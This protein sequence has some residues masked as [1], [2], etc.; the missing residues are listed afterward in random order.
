MTST[1]T[2]YSL[3]ISQAQIRL[4]LLLLLLWWNPE[5]GYLLAQ[6]IAGITTKIGTDKGLSETTNSFMYLDSKGFMWIGSLDGVNRFD[7]RQVKRYRPNDPHSRGLAGRN[8]QSNF[9]EDGKGNIWFGTE[10]SVNCLLRDKDSIAHYNLT[11]TPERK[12]FE[13]IYHFFG[14]K[15]SNEL[16]LAAKGEIWIM[17]A[18]SPGKFEQITTTNAARFAIHDDQAYSQ[19]I[20][21]GCFWNNGLGFELLYLNPQNQLLKRSTFFTGE[22]FP[23]GIAVRTKD[24]YIESPTR[25][26]FSCGEKG[27]L[28]F[29]PEQPDQYKLFPV[30]RVMEPKVGSRNLAHISNTTTL[31]VSTT[32]GYIY[33]FNTLTGQWG[34]PLQKMTEAGRIELITDAREV[35]MLRE[36]LGAYSVYD[37]GVYTT[38]M[39]AKP[40]FQNPLFP[41]AGRQKVNFLSQWKDGTIFIATSKDSAYTFYANRL[42]QKS[43]L[44]LY[45]NHLLECQSDNLLNTSVEGLGILER[46]SL[47]N[48]S[49]ISF[50]LN[51]LTEHPSGTLYLGGFAGVYVLRPGENQLGQ[52]VAAPQGAFKLHVDKQTRLWVVHDTRLEV[53]QT[54]NPSVPVLIRSYSDMGNINAISESPD[55]ARIY[56]ATASGLLM[57][58]AHTL[59]DSLLTEREGLPNQYI[60][61]VVTDRR[62]QLWLSS[63]QGIIKYMPQAPPGRQFKQYTVRNGLSS[64]EYSPG[65][66]IL[67]NTGHIWFGST[68][69]VDVFHPDSINDIGRAPQL[70]LVGLKIHDKIWRSDTTSIETVTRIDLPYDQNTL[71]LEMAALEYTDPAMNRFKVRLV[72]M[73]LDSSWTELGLQ[74]YVTYPN[75]RPGMYRFEF[76]ACN[77]EGIWQETPRLLH[78]CIHPHFTQTT[79]FRVSAILG[80]LAIVGF[81]TALYYRYRLRE[82]QLAAE[83]VQ[84]EAEK[85][86]LEL[87]NALALRDQRD[88]ISTG[89]H[90][91]LGTG[92]AKIKSSTAMTLRRFDEDRA[93][94]TLKK[95]HELATELDDNR[96]SLSWATDPEQDQLSSLV[97]RLRREVGAFFEGS[98]CAL[99]MQIADDI[100]ECAVSGEMRLRV[101]RTVRECITNIMR[102]A[103]ATEAGFQVNVQDGLLHIHIRDNGKGFD[104]PEKSDSSTGKGL[105]GMARHI[106]ELGGDIEWR[107][108]APESGMT[109]AIRLPLK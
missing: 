76:T 24:C 99:R 109:V 43:T 82:Q 1:Y 67:S 30:P 27:L 71:Q 37:E 50:D 16:W 73:G 40:S 47:K 46:K 10:S 80:I 18:D 64:N 42:R 11:E 45:F 52:P 107:R 17:R 78:I 95:V 66:G 92:L 88:R 68:Q 60:Y 104:P 6:S 91:D 86:Q 83:K 106:R 94:D 3:Q 96:R 49:L 44:P 69:G 4:F 63:N 70:A 9:F 38:P 32:E 102:H 77:A 23:S 85:Q 89:I 74:N 28:L 5:G 56:A 75:L 20:I 87:Q 57:V 12:P 81:I 33:P 7:G 14:S 21:A 13:G 55:G 54:T 15:P 100:Q 97:A 29:N 103:E 105:P 51:C 90:D 62:G 65:A 101:L 53:Y 93:R 58:D 2:M 19:R 31:L 34:K 22:S 98:T 26:W 48:K 79:W 61:A 72:G 39:G 8:V 35:V 59:K 25:L 108:N 36:G 84:R 41:V